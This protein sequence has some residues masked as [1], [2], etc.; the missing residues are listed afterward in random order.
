MYTNSKYTVF[1]V[2]YLRRRRRQGQWE[3]DAND[4]KLGKRHFER[5][6]IHVTFGEKRISNFK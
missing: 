6:A 1:T 3:S 4:I 5:P 2:G